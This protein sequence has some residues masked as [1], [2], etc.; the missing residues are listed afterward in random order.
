MAAAAAQKADLQEKLGL[1]PGIKACLVVGGGDGV[2]G[3]QGIADSV[4]HT[5]GQQ[6]AETQVRTGEGRGG[7]LKVHTP[8]TCGESVNIDLAFAWKGVRVG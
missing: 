5:L 2:G 7:R 6:G 4:G 1:K 8:L 3:L